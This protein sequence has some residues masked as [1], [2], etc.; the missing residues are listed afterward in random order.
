MKFHV[1][2]TGQQ[3]TGYG[4]GTAIDRSVNYRVWPDNGDY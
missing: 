2:D 3:D 4:Y 1:T